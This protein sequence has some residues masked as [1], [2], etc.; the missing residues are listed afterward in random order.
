LPPSHSST[1]SFSTPHNAKT[2]VTDRTVKL[3][4]Y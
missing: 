1:L 2:S 4:V 3:K